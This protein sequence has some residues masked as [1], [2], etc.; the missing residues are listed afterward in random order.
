[1]KLNCSKLFGSDQVALYLNS[2]YGA[3]RNVQFCTSAKDFVPLS[4]I[5]AQKVKLRDMV[6]E[7]A[8]FC[9]E[10]LYLDDIQKLLEAVN[11]F[12][13]ETLE[14]QLQLEAA[15]CREAAQWHTL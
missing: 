9:D 4:W 14:L 11:A 7:L 3:L 5:V 1:M 13:D 15:Q 6:D 12:Y 2:D 10:E 8:Q